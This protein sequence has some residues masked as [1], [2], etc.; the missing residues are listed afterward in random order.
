MRGQSRRDEPTSGGGGTNGD[1]IFGRNA[2]T[3]TAIDN[4]EW[5]ML[6]WTFDTTTGVLNSYFDGA[7]VDTFT[8]TD[9]S[10][11]MANSASAVGSLG[12]KAD[13]GIFLPA[14]FK[15]DE[16][17]VLD[18]AVE[19]SAIRSLFNNNVVPE[20]ATLVLVSLL[21]AAVIGFARRRRA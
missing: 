9:P 3:P 20:P 15:L 2:T 12:L 19:A 4:A 7:Q 5:H 17:W 6:S 18:Q 13:N 14:E 10:F 8:S 11:A 1:D 21:S 16:V